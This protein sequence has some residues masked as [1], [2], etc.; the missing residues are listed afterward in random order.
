MNVFI[1]FSFLQYLGCSLNTLACKSPG[2]VLIYPLKKSPLFLG[3]ICLEVIDLDQ[4]SARS[5]TVLPHTPATLPSIY[6]HSQLVSWLTWRMSFLPKFSSLFLSNPAVLLF[7]Y[8]NSRNHFRKE[9]SWFI[10]LIKL[11]QW[12][13]S[14]VHMTNGLLSPWPQWVLQW[15]LIL[16]LSHPSHLQHHVGQ[17]KRTGLQWDD[18]RAF[19]VAMFPSPPLPHYRPGGLHKVR[20]APLFCLKNPDLQ[21]Q[22]GLSLKSDFAT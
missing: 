20:Q 9:A 10:S 18:V 16:G 17:R 11:K 22:R 19:W 14:T 15:W 5:H 7:S 13:L 1:G 6:Q 21:S 4:T 2:A 12:N 3:N 8:G